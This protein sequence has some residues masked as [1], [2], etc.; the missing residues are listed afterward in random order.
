M[1]SRHPLEQHREALQT[2]LTIAEWRKSW[3]RSADFLA[4]YAGLWTEYW[5]L[6]TTIRNHTRTETR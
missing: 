2:A 4:Y 1:T 5:D 3:D 6:V